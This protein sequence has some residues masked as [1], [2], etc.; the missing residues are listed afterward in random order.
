[1]QA[2]LTISATAARVL[3]LVKDSGVTRGSEVLNRLTS[4]R[5]EDIVSAVRELVSIDLVNVK[6]DC[7]EPADFADAYLTVRPSAAA[8]AEYAIRSASR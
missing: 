5:A 2:P 8:L 7:Y 3:Q 4:T 6:G 1:M